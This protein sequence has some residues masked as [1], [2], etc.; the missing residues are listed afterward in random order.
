MRYRMFL[1][2]CVAAAS[3]CAVPAA[4][5]QARTVKVAYVPSLSGSALF[6]AIE[7]GYFKAENLAAEMLVVQSA[8]DAVAFLGIGQVDLASGNVGDTLFNAVNR[9]VDVRLVAG[10]SYYPRDPAVLSPA[11]VFVRKALVDSGAVKSVADLKGR[12][13]ALNARGGIVEYLF[14]QRLKR[15]KLSIADATVEILAFPDMT[16][17]LAN[18]VIDAAILPEPITTAARERGVGVVLDRNPVPGTLAQALLFGKNLLAE[19]EAP[20]AQAVLR[21]LRRA[22]NELQSP[23]AIMA[24]A[25]LQIYSKYTKVP[26]DTLRKTAPYFFARDLALDVGNLM[27]Q[28]RYLTEAGRVAKALPAERLVDSR[29]AIRTQ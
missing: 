13:I 26:V 11:P 12:K 20:L 19:G 22:A 29:F 27:D 23:E 24:E 9:G 1:A 8:S 21:A 17:A 28:Q 18:G 16:I 25:N 3:I 6:I 15:E 14:A 5:A 4:H 7:K 10:M 2:V